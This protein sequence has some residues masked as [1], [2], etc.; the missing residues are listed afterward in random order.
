MMG[1]EHVK[2]EEVQMLPISCF[3]PAHAVRAKSSSCA[4]S[5]CSLWHPCPLIQQTWL[6]AGV[7]PKM[8]KQELYKLIGSEKLSTRA[9]AKLR[10][11]HLLVVHNDERSKVFIGARVQETRQLAKVLSGAIFVIINLHRHGAVS[12]S[13]HK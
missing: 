10:R 1:R 6:L 7:P 9:Q 13:G 8:H 2:A 3:Y 5:Q 11:K 4:P 12:K